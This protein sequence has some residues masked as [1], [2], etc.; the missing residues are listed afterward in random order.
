MLNF[1]HE[2]NDIKD[3]LGVSV[4]GGSSEIS[5]NDETLSANKTLVAGTDA[6]VQRLASTVTRTITVNDGTVD[7][8]WFQI[9]NTSGN[10]GSSIVMT[11]SANG[12]TLKSLPRN[13]VV[14]IVWNATLTDWEI[15]AHYTNQ[16]QAINIGGNI[17]EWGLTDSVN[18]GYGLT[19]EIADAVNIGQSNQIKTGC[20]NGVAIGDTNLIQGTSPNAQVIGDNNTLTSNNPRSTVIGSNNTVA[21]NA[22]DVTSLGHNQSM[23]ADHSIGV[24]RYATSNRVGQLTRAIDLN[25][26]P[27]KQAFELYWAGETTNSTP[28]EIFLMEQANEQAWIDL[29]WSMV[30]EILI[31]ARD[32]TSGD[33]AAYKIT[34][35]IKANAT[36]TIA[37]VG[38]TPTPVV[39]GE[40]DASWDVSVSIDSTNGALA[41]NVTGDATNTVK[42]AAVGKCVEVTF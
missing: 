13:A 20:T 37:F 28:L 25:V 26:S 36:P 11:I 14:V 4:L 39:I 18:I 21:T 22:T 24:G 15:I 12:G 35:A 6:N 5:Y 40:D 2:N 31:T 9:E 29:S 16:I 7:G 41:L 34:G 32:N 8:Q 33:A 10:T 17:T 38:G 19:T 27:D 3:E 30:F 23:G 42:W 1:D